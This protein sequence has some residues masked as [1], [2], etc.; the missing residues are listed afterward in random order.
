MPESI[1]CKAP[2][3]DLWAGQTDEGELGFTYDEADQILLL[4]VDQRF[5]SDEVIARGFRIQPRTPRGAADADRTSSS[6]YRRRSAS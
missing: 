4:L 6:V 3:A 2:S 1:R 5:S